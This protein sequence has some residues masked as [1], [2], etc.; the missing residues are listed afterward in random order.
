MPHEQ[1][2]PV[3]S[4]P[5]WRDDMPMFGLGTWQLTDTEECAKSVESAIEIGYRHIDTA[6]SYGNEEGVGEG[7]RR[8]SV[9]RDE[10]FVATKVWYDD[11]G[12]ED[13][14]DSTYES[15]DKLGLATIDLLY[16]HWPAGPYGHEETLNA[17]AELADEGAIRHAGVSNYTPELITEAQSAADVMLFACQVE[18]HPLLQQRELR[19]IC[20]DAEMA[21]V[22]YSPLARGSVFEV[23]E[24]QAVA[25]KHAVS[26]AQVSLAWL[27]EKGVVPIPKSSSV[28][29]LRDNWA[30]LELDLDGE[31]IR[32]IDG[33]DRE[34]R[35]IDPGFAPE[36][37]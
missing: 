31:D 29:H 17:F 26:E 15:L 37:W 34:E 18:C 11:L 1:F 27:R 23:P 2:A 9:D 36:D 5:I 10:L 28:D 8:S 32:K 4:E 21:F 3:S 6:Q 25:E 24:I 14:L 19:E 7:I 33:I 13:V 20:E 12:Y 35:V 16:V 30:S 22:A